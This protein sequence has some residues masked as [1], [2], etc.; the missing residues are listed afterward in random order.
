MATERLEAIL[1]LKDDFSDKMQKISEFSKRCKGEFERIEAT[2]SVNDNATGKIAKIMRK[3]K[4]IKS[5]NKYILISARDQASKKVKALIR[6][7]RDI[8]PK[9]VALKIKDKASRVVG[10]LGQKLKTF[11]K[12]RW[13]ARIGVK[14][15]ASSVLGKIRGLMAIIS[16]G[17]VINATL[18]KGAELEQQTVSMQHFMGVGNKG[19]STK[20]LQ[21]MTQEY[22]KQ[23]R[24]NAN[25]TPFETGEVMK[26]GTRA[27]TIS[28]GKTDQS[29][30]LVK[31]AEDMAA[32]D[33][34]KTIGDAIE[35]LADAKMGEF[36]RLKEFGYK[37]TKEDFDKAGGDF[38]KMKS[39]EGQTLDGLFGGLSAKQSKTS[40]GMVSTLKGQ[41][42][43]VQQNIGTGILEGIK[44]TLGSMVGMFSSIGVEAGK[45]LG[46][47][48]GSGLSKTLQ[49]GSKLIKS[50]NLD[51]ILNSIQESLKPA[52][53]LFKDFFSHIQNNTPEAQG[54]MRVFGEVVKTV[55]VALK[56]PINVAGIIIRKVMGF[57]ASHSKQIQSIIRALGNVWSAVWKIIGGVLKATWVIVEPILG[58]IV[59][60]VSKI[61][62]VVNGVADAWNR[63]TNAAKNTPKPPG[64]GGG[65][66]GG[67]NH[68]S[69]GGNRRRPGSSQTSRGAGTGTNGGLA[70]AVGK[71]RVPKNDYP[72]RLHEGERVL[73]K[74]EANRLDSRSDHGVNIVIEK[75][76]V[77]EEADINKI[78]NSLVKH[79]K[80]AKAGGV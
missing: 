3:V 58:F 48:I 66:S 52:T 72:A 32:S 56:G 43:N 78:V 36:E 20:E 15:K 9:A 16:A 19:K 34:N 35:A 55:F 12:K 51:E 25:E 53:D 23:L 1:T 17:V 71:R 77:R 68:G 67:G 65:N 46:Q 80:V 70:F 21:S 33:P 11:V 73:T 2:I 41:L 31:L 8:K 63:W 69:S 10:K 39:K 75:M 4:T 26:A 37:G 54:V 42:G 61:A 6:K 79:I 64:S 22:I 49:G 62:D 13:E 76:I 47:K 29:M 28:G 38:F 5:F 50:L 24:K 59:T 45:G 40:S 57:I 74:N 60:A 7:L 44:P 30:R 14:D 27:L 18:K